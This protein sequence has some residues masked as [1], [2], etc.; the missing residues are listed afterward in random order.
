MDKI[1]YKSGVYQILNL[2]NDK[3]YIGSAYDL[4]GRRGRH[5]NDLGKRIHD[6]PKLQRAF[7]KYGKENFEFQ[8][9]LRCDIKDLLFYEQIAINIFDHKTELYNI[10][11]KASNNEGLKH[12]E[13][14]K[15]NI[16][17]R[18]SGENNPMYGRKGELSP[19]YGKKASEESR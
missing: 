6:N 5:F 11:R 16:S 1:K 17:K 13:E 2:I 18:T 15:K 9:I 4:I 7:N 14:T 3:R 12:T 19:K 8:I 10:R